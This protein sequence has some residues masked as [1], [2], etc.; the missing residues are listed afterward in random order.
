MMRAAGLT[1]FE[2]TQKG[3]Y[4]DSMTDFQDPLYRN[5]VA[6]LPPGSKASDYI[7]SLDIAATKPR[8]SCCGPNCCS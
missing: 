3:K 4:I 8:A 7:T 6:K 2:L 5:I 1:E